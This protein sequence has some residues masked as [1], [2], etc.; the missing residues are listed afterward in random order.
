M[1]LEVLVVNQMLEMCDDARYLGVI[2]DKQPLL[3]EA[4]L[5]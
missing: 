1:S 2:V 3:E 4:H 5:A